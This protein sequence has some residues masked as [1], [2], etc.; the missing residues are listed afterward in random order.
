MDGSESP[1]EESEEDDEEEEEDDDCEEEEDDDEEEEESDDD[2]ENDDEDDEEDDD[3]SEQEDEGE[4]EEEAADV[5]RTVDVPK[6]TPEA[7]CSSE[8][9][10]I[11]EMNNE[12]IQIEENDL[13]V[14][15]QE[16]S[17][18]ISQNPEAL[19]HEGS[20]A[21]ILHL[22]D[23]CLVSAV[24]VEA[25]FSDEDENEDACDS[26]KPAKINMSLQ[27]NL[28]HNDNE[29]D[30]DD[31]DEDEELMGIKEEASRRITPTFEEQ[32]NDIP[33]KGVSDLNVSTPECHDIPTTPPKVT[34]T[35]EADDD[36]DDWDD[37]EED[38]EAETKKPPNLSMALLALKKPE[39]PEVSWGSGSDK[40]D[41]DK[42]S[43]IEEPQTLVSLEPAGPV[44]TRKEPVHTDQNDDSEAIPV[45]MIVGCDD[46][47]DDEQSINVSQ[48]E[49]VSK[50]SDSQV[51]QMQYD[52][53]SGSVRVP[54]M[55][56]NS[57]VTDSDSVSQEDECT[58]EGPDQSVSQP[59]TNAE[60]I[61]NPNSPSPSEY[62]NQA[63][64]NVKDDI[65]VEVAEGHSKD[66]LAPQEEIPY[67]V[68]DDV[69]LASD[70]DGED[71]EQNCV[72][73]SVTEERLSKRRSPQVLWR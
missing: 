54:E 41:G 58:D 55:G 39:S 38:E 50:E 57:D 48:E 53:A 60:K 72:N 30:W 45:S 64:L 51:N 15:E 19:L 24:R 65:S 11:K 61:S 12:N 17:A 47:S 13:K 21:G 26:P 20:I 8:L 34:N 3:N 25:K 29:E 46:Q 71:M 42:P 9:D 69:S 18:D 16:T 56:Q 35:A 68:I 4:E 5:C 49:D 28:S 2:D 36:D 6:L 67:T 63:D 37:V 7:L 44:T 33:L 62:L 1:E 32:P 73:E 23:D 31:G 59:Q 10:Q 43:D 40:S 66:E 14:A 70:S 52:F 22:G 27:R